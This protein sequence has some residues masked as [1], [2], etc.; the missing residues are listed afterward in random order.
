MSSGYFRQY[1]LGG[2]WNGGFIPQNGNFNAELHCENNDLVGTLF[3]DKSI[4]SLQTQSCLS[5]LVVGRPVDR[6]HTWTICHDLETTS[7]WMMWIEVASGHRT[8]QLNIRQ[9][10]C[11]PGFPSQPRLGRPED[12][13][14]RI[15]IVDIESRRLS[16]QILYK[17]H[18]V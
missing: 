14:I 11:L 7:P 10:S 13:G 15:P 8:W 16:H 6:W 4:L 3:A 2:V 18:W 12:E 9:R 5:G 17:L 1:P